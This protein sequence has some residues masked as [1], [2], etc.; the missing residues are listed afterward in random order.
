MWARSS[1]MHLSLWSQSPSHGRSGPLFK[2][3]TSGQTA[4]MSVPWEAG[5]PLF[6]CIFTASAAPPQPSCA[7]GGIM[8]IKC[9]CAPRASQFR[10][11]IFTKYSSAPPICN[12]SII[13]AGSK[14]WDVHVQIAEPPMPHMI[15][16]CTF[17]Q[18]GNCCGRKFGWFETSCI[19]L[20]K[21]CLYSPIG[22]TLGKVSTGSF[23]SR[24]ES[25]YFHLETFDR[26]LHFETTH[27]TS[28]KHLY[29]IGTELPILC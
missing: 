7:T 21:K 25:S 20:Q 2:K 9:S 13:T 19:I 27:S 26:S 10:P 24:P 11:S 16:V 15:Q 12:V 5:N 4:N 1:R 14:L 28:T 29:V 6:P 3:L 22:P 18:C 8:F 17:A 23:S